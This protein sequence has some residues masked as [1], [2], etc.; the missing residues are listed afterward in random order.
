MLSAEENALLTQTG[1][2]TPGGAFMRRY[3]QPA[4]LSREL[5]TE[6]LAVRLLDADFV[7]FRNERGEPCMLDIHCAHRKADLSYGRLE[8]GTLRCLY[9]GW[10]FGGDGTCLEQPGEPAESTYR[11]RIKQPAYPARDVCGVI[12]AYLGPGEPPPLPDIPWLT[13]PAENSWATKLLHEC[14]YLQGNE[15]NVDPQHL[16]FLHRVFEH[17]GA[18]RLS[19][20]L[21]GLDAAPQIDVDETTFGLRIF[22]IRETGEGEKY[23]RVSNFIMPHGSAFPAG[24]VVDPAVERLDENLHYS[25]HFHVP[26]DDFN[27]WKY[28]VMFRVDGPVDVDFLTR[29]QNDFTSE[30]SFERPRAARNRYMQ[31]R[32]EQHSRTFTGMGRNFQDHDR[33]A[34]ESQGR[35]L[36]RTTEHLATTDKA[37]IAMRR[38]MLAAIETVR[39]GGNPLMTDPHTPNPCRDIIVR[40]ARVPAGENPHDVW[41]TRVAP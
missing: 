36:D 33:F 9:H 8:N 32:E 41:R 15:G 28:R 40:S 39:D 34:V 25:L 6:P 10:R 29:T 1:P 18:P 21:T 13:A 30:D 35:V 17:D 2:G 37:L 24:L 38:Q 12:F 22:A 27:H 7:L 20:L 4:A 11:A 5:G 19:H 23:V 16:S 14:N 3:W 31:N 26:I